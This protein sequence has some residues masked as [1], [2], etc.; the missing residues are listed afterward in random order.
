MTVTLSEKAIAC[1]LIAET[2]KAGNYDSVWNECY[3]IACQRFSEKA[4]NLKML[5]LAR[6]GYID[7]G[8]SARTGWL[9]EKGKAAL[10]PHVEAF[11]A[12]H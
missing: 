1:L 3:R 11:L 2:H 6:R 7:Y 8:V 5:E 12:T 10:Q 9:T 4:V